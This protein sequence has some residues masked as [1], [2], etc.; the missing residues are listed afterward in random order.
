MYEVEISKTISL[1][2]IGIKRS[3]L[4]IPFLL[5]WE[6]TQWLPAIAVLAVK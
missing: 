3:M 4:S 6:S 2:E 1:D 5:A